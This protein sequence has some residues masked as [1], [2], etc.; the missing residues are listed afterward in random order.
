MQEL[1]RSAARI[2]RVESMIKSPVAC[3][4]ANTIATV[5]GDCLKD[6]RPQPT[7]PGTRW[8][9]TQLRHVGN[10]DPQSGCQ[11]NLVLLLLNQNLPDI[12]GYCEL[13]ERLAL[14]NSL[15]VMADG[16]VLVF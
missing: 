4:R 3:P 2:K 8:P 9:L 7:T 6:T 12:L 16:L 1:T 15:P 14:S 11:V 10:L 5:I 13:A